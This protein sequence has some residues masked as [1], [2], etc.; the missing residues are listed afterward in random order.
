MNTTKTTVELIGPSW[1][2]NPPDIGSRV[3]GGASIRVDGLSKAYKVRSGDVAALQDINLDIAGGEIL[4]II[5]RSGAGK[6]TLIRCL[7][8]LERP[9]EGKVWIDGREITALE[10]K[11]LRAAR[12]RIGMIFQ[13]FN[14]AAQRTAFDNVAL[15]LI[16]AGERR[17]RIEARVMELLDL[18]GLAD[19][20]DAY[21][22]QL[23]GG[24]KQRVGIARA[25]ATAPLVLLCD[26]ATSALDPETTSSVLDL[27]QAINRQMGL[28][29]VLVTHEMSVV[30]RIAQRVLVLDQGRIVEQGD[31]ATLFAAPQNPVT[32][33]LL[34]VPPDA[35]AAWLRV[36]GGPD[37]IAGAVSLLHANGIS[38]ES[39][40]HE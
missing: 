11:D 22:A 21:P 38:V 27:L 8:R 39:T 2:L 35:D 30:R 16:L 19:R 1:G 15:P 37:V 6:S 4:A 12:R 28:S 33:E 5:G 20:R 31:V 24:Q 32:R 29:I 18:V 13:T 14:L 3:T 17:K 10:G 9:S 7:N 34:R 26:E 40:C 23:S 36:A 25:L